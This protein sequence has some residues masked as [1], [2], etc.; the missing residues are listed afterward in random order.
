MLAPD[1]TTIASLRL[2]QLHSDLA[3]DPG[4][5][6]ENARLDTDLAVF[7]FVQALNFSGNQGWIF[8]VVPASRI[9]ESADTRTGAASQS[10]SGLG[11]VQLGFVYGV[12]G[13]PALRAS[14]YADHR[15]GLAVNLLAK[16]FFPTGNYSQ[17]RSINVGANRWAVRLGAP[18]VYAIGTRM[19]DPHLITIEAMPTI[20]FFGANDAPY[21]AVRTH[22]K[23]LF[24]FEGHV[25]RGFSK[26][27][28]AGIDL[29]WREGGPV[30]A[31]GA[32]LGNRQRALS[33]AATGT[34]ALGRGW[35]LRLSGGGVV[36]R[37]E[38]GPNGWML[39][40][41]IGAAF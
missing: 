27:F 6:V 17:Q 24:L 11:D 14:D 19:G 1:K 40:S 39:R 35:S 10:T 8:L 2:H 15:P 33:L 34:L 5:V 29:L 18:I 20:S 41:I 7:Q 22:Q 12:H 21:G 28:W 30:V 9:T 4:T 32:D 26:D 3:V 23:P 37:N 25:T 31:D 38:H 13:T 36:A 16:L